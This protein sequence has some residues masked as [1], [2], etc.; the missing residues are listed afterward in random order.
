[1]LVDADELTTITRIW[2]DMFAAVLTA[3]EK[4]KHCGVLGVFAGGYAKNTLLTFG[5]LDVFDEERCLLLVPESRAST[6]D[7]IR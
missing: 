6:W 1:M 7:M 4:R 2:T 5:S 3:F